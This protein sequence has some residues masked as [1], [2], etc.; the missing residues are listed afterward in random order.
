MRRR[1][2]ARQGRE[3]WVEEGR[4]WEVL[5]GGGGVGGEWLGEGI[6]R[7]AVRGAGRCRRMVNSSDQEGIGSSDLQSP[8][9]LYQ[10][11]K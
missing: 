4:D 9:L 6:R 2:E 7:E 11:Q 8:N 3:K 10:N 1:A 5:A